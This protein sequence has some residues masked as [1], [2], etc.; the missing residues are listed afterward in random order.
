MEAILILQFKENWTCKYLVQQ[1]E[2]YK[3][4]KWQIA[5]PN[6][7]EMCIERQTSTKP[8]NFDGNQRRNRYQQQKT[9]FN[10]GNNSSYWLVKSN[11][12]NNSN[13]NT[14]TKNLNPQTEM[15]LIRD[16]KHLRCPMKGHNYKDYR[17]RQAKQPMVTTAQVLSGRRESTLKWFY[18]DKMKKWSDFKAT[19][20][21]PH[22]FSKVLVKANRHPTLALENLH[23]QE[24]DWINSKFVHLYHIPT[25]LS[26]KKT[27]TI[28]IRGSQARIDNAYTIQL[29]WIRYIEEDTFYVAHLSGSDTILGEPALSAMNI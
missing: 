24:G 3:G 10:P 11:S 7:I 12:T 16:K 9:G 15:E 19:K 20:P 29:D 18:K 8:A 6:I 28:A 23:P 14:I 25:R 27:L 26:E 5:I 13:W 21:E 2:A 22:N 1:T 4:L 17:K